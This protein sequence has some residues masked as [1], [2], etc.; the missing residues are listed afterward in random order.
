[1]SCADKELCI[2][3]S[4]C[5]TEMQFL[6]K[7][8]SQEHNMCIHMHANVCVCV[9]ECVC[10]QTYRAAFSLFCAARTYCVERRSH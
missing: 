10:I 2:F 7:N 6:S 5:M 9:D 1:M 8:V 4:A 3:M